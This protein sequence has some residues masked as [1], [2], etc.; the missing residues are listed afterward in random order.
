MYKNTGKYLSNKGDLARINHPYI[1]SRKYKNK[2][3]PFKVWTKKNIIY[4]R[5]KKS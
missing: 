1:G 2:A 5:V 3:K 4:F